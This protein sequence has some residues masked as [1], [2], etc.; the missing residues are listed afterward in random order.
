MFIGGIRRVE[1]QRPLAERVAILAHGQ[2]GGVPR[3]RISLIKH[4]RIA[5]EHSFF[6]IATNQLHGAPFVTLGF[7]VISAA[8]VVGSLRKVDAFQEATGSNAE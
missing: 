3:Q 5:V 6:V 8:L 1:T 2:H 4:E 7:T